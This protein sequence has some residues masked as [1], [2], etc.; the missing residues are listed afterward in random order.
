MG[1]MVPLSLVRQRQRSK[2]LC[3]APNDVSSSHTSHTMVTWVADPRSNTTT[4]MQTLAVCAFAYSPAASVSMCMHTHGACTGN[5]WLSGN[6][7]V[8]CMHT[9]RRST[10][11]T[12]HEHRSAD[13]HCGNTQYIYTTHKI[14]QQ[15]QTTVV[16]LLWCS[17]IMLPSGIPSSNEEQ[18]WEWSSVQIRAR[19]SFWAF[20]RAAGRA[21]GTTLR[22]RGQDDARALAARCSRSSLLE[23]SSVP[24][25]LSL[26]VD[27]A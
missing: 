24:L 22:S 25:S 15:P 12:S 11:T 2:C 13:P 20:Q 1:W 17:G 10:E 21:G 5:K 14:F 27:D 7:Q 26:I 16:A 18:R 4:P 8:L 3:T 6:T 23:R 9:T 19:A